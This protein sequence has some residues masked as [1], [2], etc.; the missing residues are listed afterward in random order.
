MPV[1]CNLAASALQSYRKFESKQKSGHLPGLSHR[2]RHSRAY[3]WSLCDQP[4]EVL[5]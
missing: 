2:A 3:G 4:D 5:E 1:Y